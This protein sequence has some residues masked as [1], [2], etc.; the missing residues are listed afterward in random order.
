[1]KCP[2]FRDVRQTKEARPTSGTSQKR[3]GHLGLAAHNTGE[4]EKSP[5]HAGRMTLK[6]YMFNLNNFA[7]Y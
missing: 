1:M 5:I 2:L 6:S 4:R 7:H 3:A